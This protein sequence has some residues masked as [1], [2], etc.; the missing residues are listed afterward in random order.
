[1]TDSFKEET[2]KFNN[3]V[4]EKKAINHDIRAQRKVLHKTMIKKYKWLFIAMD[5]IVVF[6]ILI[7]Y[8]AVIITNMLVV[9]ENPDVEIQEANAIQAELNDYKQHVDGQTVMMAIFIQAIMWGVLLFVYLYHRI[10]IGT[11]KEML[12][13]CFIVLFYLYLISFDFINDFGYLLGKLIYGG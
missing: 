2:M 11:Y 10:T 3:L 5:I 1:M 13:M 12:L 6:M 9:R 7:N 4:N 8:G